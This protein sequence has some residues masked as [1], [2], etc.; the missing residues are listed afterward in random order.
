MK[1]KV[2]LLLMLL[3]FP[4]NVF[5]YSNYVIPGGNNIG[6]EVNNNGIIVV[7][8]YKINNKYNNNDLK[9]G[10]II[11][12]VN[13]TSVYTI[14]EMVKSIEDNVKNNKIKLKIIRN[15]KEMSID[16]NLV[17]VE[18]IYKTG[19]YVKDSISGIGTLTYIDPETRIYGALGH[20]II[21]SNSMTSVEVRDGTIF[22]SFVTSID[23]STTGNA[24]TKNA[25]FNE[26]NI[27]G[28]VKKNTESG[29]YGIYKEN[30]DK[31]NLIEVGNPE[32]LK[33]GKAYI[34][35]V[36]EGN[37]VKMY[38]INITNISY[39]SK[40][41]NISFEVVSEELLNITGG[42]V[43]GMSGSPIIQNNKI[44][45]AVTHVVVSKPNTGYGIFITSMLSE[46]ES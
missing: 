35:T 17:N 41:K 37:E 40:I 28:D 4:L 3:L 10:D 12:G 14:D 23:R 25:K 33:L 27:Y 16:F 9:L 11:I 29:I 21:E 38:E 32:D 30:I 44:F 26:D 18:G 5:A 22:E 42:I 39:N 34:Y 6:I 31:N 1:N 19:L 45:G 15:N 7:G 8:F 13:D 43:Q 2:I 36:V 20:E 46:G 24:G